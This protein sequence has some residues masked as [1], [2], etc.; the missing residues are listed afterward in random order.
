ML[1][2]KVDT[3]LLPVGRT[4][5]TAFTPGGAGHYLW[6]TGDKLEALRNPIRDFRLDGG[7]YLRARP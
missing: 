7:A 1:Q 6:G 5:D 4:R 3:F 2:G